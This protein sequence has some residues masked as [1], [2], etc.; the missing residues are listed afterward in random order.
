MARKYGPRVI[1]A[2]VPRWFRTQT[3]L[4]NATGIAYSSINDWANGKADPRMEQLERVTAVVE[5]VHHVKLDPVELMHG[6]QSVPR[7]HV[8]EH[9]DWPGAVE[10]A[11]RRRPGRFPDYAYSFSGKTSGAKM[12]EHLEWTNVIELTQFWWDTVSNEELM[13]A[14]TEAVRREMEE[15]DAA[16][17]AEL[18]AKKPEAAQVPTEPA[19]ATHTP[20]PEP[21]RAKKPPEPPKRPP[22]RAKGRR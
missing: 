16:I 2:L 20:P 10:E 19:P 1:A 18:R 11:K 5:K 6:S 7:G 8:D 22:G 12:P 4:Q 21:A 15:E 9:P 3:E 14:E 17:E 13:E